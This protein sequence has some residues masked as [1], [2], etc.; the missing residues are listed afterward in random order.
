MVV[1]GVEYGAARAVVARKEATRK[2]FE[3]YI[4]VEL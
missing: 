4:I 3:V 2:G 1:L